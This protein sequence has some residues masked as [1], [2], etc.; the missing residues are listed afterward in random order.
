MLV[1]PG[2]GITMTK[3]DITQLIEEFIEDEFPNLRYR[4]N[5]WGDDLWGFVLLGTEEDEHRGYD[6]YKEAHIDI[7]SCHA[8][9]RIPEG[10]DGPHHKAHINDLDFLDKIESWVNDYFVFLERHYAAEANAKANYQ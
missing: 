9:F 10:T 2:I 5:W 7:K 4:K 6:F 3:I 1:V 8:E